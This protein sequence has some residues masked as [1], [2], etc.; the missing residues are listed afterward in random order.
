V[1]YRVLRDAQRVVFT[2]EEEKIRARESFWLYRAKRD[3]HRLWHL[4]PP[5]G[6]AALA[7]R[8]VMSIRC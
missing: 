5:A 1:K 3:G 7:Q 8:F 2:S 4:Q 6:G